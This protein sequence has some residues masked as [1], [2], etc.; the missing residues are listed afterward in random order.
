[1]EDNCQNWTDRTQ[2]GDFIYN[3]ISKGDNFSTCQEAGDSD[4]DGVTNGED[5][6]ANTPAGTFV[7]ETG[8]PT[9][10]GDSDGDGV[11]DAQDQ[12]E[13]TPLGTI[14]NRTGCEIN[15]EFVSN[16]C[17]GF[18]NFQNYVKSDFSEAVQANFLYWNDISVGNPVYSAS[19]SDGELVVQCTKADPNFAAQGFSFGEDSEGN[20]VSIDVSA[21]KVAKLD[22]RF[23]PDPASNYESDVVLFRIQIEDA[24]G[25]V[26]NT[27][28]TELDHRVLVD[29]NT[30]RRDVTFD[31]TDGKHLL[32]DDSQDCSPCVFD[33]FDFTRVTKIIMF[34][35]PGAGAVWS[36]PEFTGNW[37]IDNFSFGFDEDNTVP[38]DLI[39]DDDGDGVRIED[40]ICKNTLPGFDVDE[41]GCAAYQQDADRDGVSDADDECPATPTGAE[42][43]SIGC[44]ESQADDDN[45]MDQCPLTQLGETVNDVGCSDSQLDE[46]QDDDNVINLED[47]CPNTPAGEIVD[48][49]GCSDSQLDDDQDGTPNGED[50][51][52]NDPNKIEEGV[53]GCGT[54]E[55]NCAVDCNGDID[56]TAYID[57]CSTCVGG[58]TG[59]EA[60]IG[61]PFNDVINQIP[62][63]IQVENYD[64][65]GQGVAYNDDDATNN[66][67]G[68]RTNEGVDIEL[69]ENSD[70]NYNIGYTAVGEWIN[71]SVNVE[72]TG[73]YIISYRVASERS[74]G[75]WHLEL[76]G[77]AMSSSQQ[78]LPSTDGWQTYTVLTTAPVN[79]LAGK[80]VLALVVDGPDFN[81]DY[82]EFTLDAITGTE[83][84]IDQNKVE[85]YPNP[86]QGTVNLI[87]EIEAWEL[88]D[89]YGNTMLIGNEK[90]IDMSQMTSGVY[91]VRI[92]E[93]THKLIKE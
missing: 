4:S 73:N 41:E 3:V 19:V 92:G 48:S 34:C 8:C 42:V 54:I 77:Q 51:C 2:T 1:V 84:G 75:A 63:I 21:Y 82:I 88:M 7:D 14:V 28:P 29:V 25:N 46:D 80:H 40:D 18:N 52:P 11:I 70:N 53:C 36:Q 64:L 24:D 37:R 91:Y 57:N 72:N 35:N 26:I 55:G 50:E 32:F 30:W 9:L 66:G 85:I 76:D 6:C 10:Q 5:Q 27:D 69:S 44:D 60:C 83:S 17:D 23:D 22:L 31:F 43:N 86:T 61:N 15:N 81:M 71:Y 87:G 38:C 33:E 56:G 68:Y 13:N 78:A 93:N 49:K 74:E 65:G 12:C 59:R 62:G 45:D 67:N 39:R 90:I 16:V 20:D 58:E 79:I 47:V 89:I